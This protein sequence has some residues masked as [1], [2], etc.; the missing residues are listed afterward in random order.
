MKS[1]LIAMTAGTALALGVAAVSTADAHSRTAKASLAT[2]DGTRI[3]TVEFKTERRSTEVRVRL[4]GAP[5]VDAFH[6]F[7]IHANDVT[8][9]GDGCIAD[10]AAAPATWFVSADGHYN[11]TGQEHSHHVGDM[12]VVFVNTD[13]SVETRFE[14][15]RI[16]PGDLKGKVVILHAGADNYANIPLGTALTQYTAN[17]PDATAA[18]ARTGNAG[19]RVACGEIRVR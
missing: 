16:N 8:T 19:D 15:D 17:S 3:G 9:N 13:G 14:I 18:T 12:P 7:H 6:G 2:A 4:S 11:P 5:G 10:P 1:R